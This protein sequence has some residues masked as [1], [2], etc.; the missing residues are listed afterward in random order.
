MIFNPL[1][2]S[3]DNIKVILHNVGTISISHVF[4]FTK[5]IYCCPN[6]TRSTPISLTSIAINC[7]VG[8]LTWIVHIHLK[9]PQGRTWDFKELILLKSVGNHPSSLAAMTYDSSLLS[10]KTSLKSVVPCALPL[11]FFLE[12]LLSNVPTELCVESKFSEVIEDLMR[13]VQI[14]CCLSSVVIKS[15]VRKE[16]IIENLPKRIFSLCSQGIPCIQGQKLF[17]LLVE[18]SLMEPHMKYYTH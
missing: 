15:A 11:S 12:V 4:M 14:M 3:C 13:W 2:V 1:R 10:V 9:V 7:N 5:P 8:L 18:V 16:F 17:Y 6:R